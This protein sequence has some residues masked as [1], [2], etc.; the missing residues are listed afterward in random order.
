[1]RPL[2][3]NGGYTIELGEKLYTKLKLS[4]GAMDDF[5]RPIH[6][7]TN[8]T[9]KIGEYAEDED[10]KYT[11]SV[12]LGTIYADLGLSNSGIPAGNVTYYVDGEKTTFTKDIVKGSLDDV[13]GNGALTQVWYDSAKNTATITVI[14][15]YF[16]QIAAAYK[17]STT[18]DAYV[19][20]ASTGNTG[21][22]ST[23]ETDDAYAVDD[24]VLYTYSKMTGA[25]GVKSMNKIYTFE[26]VTFDEAIVS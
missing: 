26:V 3:N 17:A 9:K 5:G 24:Y 19:L 2:T 25:T 11:D 4:S 10:A 20:L 23:Y 21:L 22:G 18:K 16:A 8:D 1:M 13:G 15:T 6:I 12:K 14:N 7:W